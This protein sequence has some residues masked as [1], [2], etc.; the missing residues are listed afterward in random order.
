MLNTKICYAI[1]FYYLFKL[2]K[3]NNSKFNLITMNIVFEI[4]RNL[5]SLFIKIIFDLRI[6]TLICY[7]I[8]KK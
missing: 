2:E 1:K 4:V 8:K 6:K 5:I 7:L 3:L